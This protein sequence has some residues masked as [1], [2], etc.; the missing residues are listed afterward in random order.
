MT[1]TTGYSELRE[2][3]E[4]MFNGLAEMP[5]AIPKLSEALDRG[6]DLTNVPNLDRLARGILLPHTFEEPLARLA[7]INQLWD[8]YENNTTTVV[9]DTDDAAQLDMQRRI[10]WTTEG[11]LYDDVAERFRSALPPAV[12]AHLDQNVAA[13]R[14][15][16]MEP[17]K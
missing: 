16:G 17:I 1:T 3:F 11:L 12:T 15:Q 10:L 13:Y 14:R 4:M 5:W 9:V 7:L 6:D 8:E 2:Q